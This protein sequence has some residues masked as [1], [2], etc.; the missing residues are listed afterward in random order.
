M[1]ATITRKAID[2]ALAPSRAARGAAWLDDHHR[3]WWSPIDA[4]DF[5][6]ANHSK[7]PLAWVYADYAKGLNAVMRIMG[8]P[9][10]PYTILCDLGFDSPLGPDDE[11]EAYHR[12]LQVAWM[13]EVTGRQGVK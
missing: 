10:N 12:A 13:K 5:Q 11:R 3:D 4:G 8:G 2:P 7:C 9:K 1:T 6:V